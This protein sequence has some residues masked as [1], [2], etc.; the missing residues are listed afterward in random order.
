MSWT[1]ALSLAFTAGAVGGLANAFAVWFFG[2]R[3]INQLLGVNIAPLLTTAFIYSKVVWGGL[4]GFLFMIEPQQDLICK[5][6]IIS[7]FPT[8]VQLFYV[9]PKD[10][11][12]AAGLKLGKL[13]PLLVVFFN[14]VWALAAATWISM[15]LP[16]PL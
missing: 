12:G 9:F 13:T 16:L 3:N 10:Q 14:L 15:S 11:K 6:I 5:A 7:I 1:Q 4:W 2:N 8:L